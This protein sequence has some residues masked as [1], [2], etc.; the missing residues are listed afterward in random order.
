MSDGG[1]F[2]H[3]ILSGSRAYIWPGSVTW[4][5]GSVWWQTTVLVALALA[6]VALMLG[7]R[8]RIASIACWFLA[9]SVQARTVHT[10]YGFDDEMRGL[11]FF[12]ILVAWGSRFS[13]DAAR[14]PTQDDEVTGPAAVGLLSFVALMWMSTGLMKVG[15]AWQSDLTAVSVAL[16]LD[17]FRGL[18]GPLLLDQPWLARGLTF[19]VPK[20]EVIAP[21]L[22]LLPIRSPWPRA[23]GVVTLALMCTGLSLTMR[24]GLFQ[25]L[26][27]AALLPFVPG[28][29]WSRAGRLERGLDAA[30]AHLGRSR[31][32]APDPTPVAG[33]RFRA[34]RYLAVVP[35][36]VVMAWNVGFVAAFPDP[37][38]RWI[39]LPARTLQLNP[40]WHMF[41]PGPRADNTWMIAAGTD[42]RGARID[43]LR[44]GAPVEPETV[45]A[46]PDGLRPPRPRFAQPDAFRWLRFRERLVM[47][48]PQAAPVYARYLCRE[49][50]EREADGRVVAIELLLAGE[51]VLRDLSRRPREPRTLAT[52]VCDR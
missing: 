41:A 42:S 33:S 34:L 43:V 32:G 28:A 21:V 23:L 39:A 24:I 12:G 50:N 3:E 8:T 46:G 48:H 51:D 52:V 44:S 26:N 17:E 49:W 29:A 25:I 20:L 30:F 38:P 11:L 35:L 27:L 2:P 5:S 6:A 31:A 47:H 16:T 37:P 19:V 40:Y 36:A 13:V 10:T 14:R 9:V 7:W 18:L 15:P 1:A 22:L 4:L 45:V